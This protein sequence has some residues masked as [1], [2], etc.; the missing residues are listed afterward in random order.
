[1]QDFLLVQHNSYFSNKININRGVHQ[2]G[3][4]SSFLF[5][6]CVE[7]LAIKLRSDSRIEGIPVEDI[8]YLFDQFADDMDAYLQ[9]DPQSMLAL[10]ENLDWFHDISGFCINYDKT[11]VYRIGSLCDT[12]AMYYVEKY[13]VWTNDLVN[14]LGIWVTHH[15]NIM[16]LN[17]DPLLEKTKNILN[18]WS[19][20]NLSLAGKILIIN[21]LVV[22]L[23]VYKMYVLPKI[24]HKYLKKLMDIIVKFLWNNG[25]S[26]ISLSI[27]QS[28][29]DSGG[30]NLINFVNKETALKVGWLPVIAADEK[31]AK[32]AYH[33]MSPILLEK[34]WECNL[35]SM[36][37]VDLFPKHFW[38][39]V[40]C[41]WSE[42][43]FV[44]NVRNPKKT[45]NMVQL[46]YSYRC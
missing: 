22:S 43:N 4:N 1:M 15:N 19:K 34:I 2:G 46:T 6:H 13:L 14:I 5:L 17:Y 3:P 35:H 28:S 38:T 24:P 26:K 45:D 21:T 40:L 41:A 25:R 30:L 29:K 33:K 42:L 12:N 31:V 32:L 36:H 39:D 18:T 23:F 27:L 16:E 37:V 44:K 11:S 8:T 10:F 7:I 9:E 20:R